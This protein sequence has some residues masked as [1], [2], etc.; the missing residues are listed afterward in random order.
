VNILWYILFAKTHKN[1]NGCL[2]QISV[3]HETRCKVTV[4]CLCSSNGDGCVSAWTPQ[5]LVQF[6]G[7][8]SGE[9]NG[10]HAF[11]GGLWVIHSASGRVK[12]P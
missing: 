12:S 11:P 8:L 7:I 2:L 5:L 10:R 3:K 6:E 1:C 4:I 9:D